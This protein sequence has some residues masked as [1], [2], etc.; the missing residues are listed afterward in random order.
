VTA[1]DMRR[2][3]EMNCLGLLMP[4]TRSSGIDQDWVAQEYYLWARARALRGIAD[5]QLHTIEDAAADVS[6]A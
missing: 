5:Y 4:S 1:D 2:I 6:S 3:R